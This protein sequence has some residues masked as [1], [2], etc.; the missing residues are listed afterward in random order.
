MYIPGPPAACRVW[1]SRFW[2]YAKGLPCNSVWI[3]SWRLCETPSPRRWGRVSVCRRR[4]CRSRRWWNLQPAH[5]PRRSTRP[6][7]NDAPPAA[8][9]RPNTPA[10]GRTCSSACPRKRL[11]SASSAGSS[12]VF[13]QKK[14]AFFKWCKLSWDYN[15]RYIWLFLSGSSVC[16]AS[17]L[18]N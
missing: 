11:E 7:A 9:D 12:N 16:I 14:N 15:T 17:A 4:S 8:S 2:A 6:E 13:L 18:A 10:T 5:A 3:V 1:A